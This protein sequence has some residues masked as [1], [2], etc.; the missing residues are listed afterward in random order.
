MPSHHQPTYTYILAGGGM[1]GL[2]LAFYL[3]QSSVP[4]DSILIID[5]AEKN[6]RDKTW[7]Y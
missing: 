3:N 1:A 7:C 4:F 5:Q 2:S 6:T